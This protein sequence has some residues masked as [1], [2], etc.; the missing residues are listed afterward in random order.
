MRASN[1]G[2]LVFARFRSARPDVKLE[3]IDGTAPS[4]EEQLVTSNAEVAIYY[5]PIGRPIPA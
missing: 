3:L 5:V 1:V 4:V 2:A